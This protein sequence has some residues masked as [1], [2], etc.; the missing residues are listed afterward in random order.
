M[1]ANNIPIPASLAPFLQEYDLAR[2]DPEPAASIL[3][4]RTLQY[5]NRSELRWLFHQ[6]PRSDIA[7]WVKRFGAERLAH[8]HL[9]FWRIVLEIP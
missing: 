5:G 3:I 7:A 6:Y 4:E 2:L 8:P 1:P 9:D